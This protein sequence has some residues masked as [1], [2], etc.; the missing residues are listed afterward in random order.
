MGRGAPV[1]SLLVIPD[2]PRF[3]GDTD[4]SSASKQIENIVRS[5]EWPTGACDPL[6]NLYSSKSMKAHDTLVWLSDVGIAV[7]AAVVSERLFT[8]GHVDEV[9]VWKTLFAFMKASMAMMGACFERE[10]FD[11]TEQDFIDTLAR[12]E[13][14]IPSK[15]LTISVSR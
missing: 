2:S 13:T 4:V 1:I 5:L 10:S 11:D 9:T 12:L 7:L 6:K 15:L 14:V 8:N 3:P